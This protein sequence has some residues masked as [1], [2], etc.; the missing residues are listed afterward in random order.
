MEG[1]EGARP[2]GTARAFHEGTKHSWES[3]RRR[4]HFLDW[5]NRPHPFKRYEDLERVPLPHPVRFGRPALEA[6]LAEGGDGRGVLDA[7]LLAG[8]LFVSAGVARRRR[9]DGEEFHF[10]TYAS[11]GA[12]YPVEVYVACGDLGAVPAG[13]YHFDPLG[14]ELV[15]LRP[16][17]HR[18]SL[19][20]AAAAETSVAQAP[21]VLVFTGVPWKTA[22]KYTERGYRH[23]F[24]DAGMMLANLLAGARAAH[25]PVRVVLGFADREVEDLLGL[26]GV[27]E[28]PLC[29]VAVGR[30]EAVAPASAPPHPARFPERPFSRREF[31][32]QAIREVN[33]AG[34]LDVE[35]VQAWRARAGALAPGPSRPPAEPF[36]EDLPR[37]S[38]DDVV[39]RRG[40]AR[41][42]APGALPLEVLRTVLSA[43]TRGAPTDYALEG[44]S[45]VQPYLVVNAVRGMVPGAYVWERGQLHLLQ[46]GRFAAQAGYLCLE[47]RL[48]MDASVTAFLMAPLDRVLDVAGDRGY[49][50]AQLEGG[51]AGGFMYLGAYA[52]RFGATGLTFYDDDV[53]GFFSPHAAGKACLL[54][55]A[56]GE[57]PRLRRGA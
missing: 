24:W 48:A 5:A 8:L 56:V 51:V 30:G 36:R 50:L 47:Q 18:P 42:F 9:L 33:D 43:A 32:F 12:L 25:L 45:L 52:H 23:L 26:D 49:R 16:G 1:G 6:L 20:R 28:F 15:R 38:V 27:R 2:G 3:V 4:G 34:R 10:R 13:V 31:T 19:V 35:A 44:S 22:W 39:R 54:V 53:T 17:D 21:A 37:D 55:V 14:F 11:A 40:S 57:S 41:F 29:L 46:E 7:S